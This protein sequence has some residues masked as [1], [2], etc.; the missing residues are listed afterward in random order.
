MASVSMNGKSCKCDIGK[1]LYGIPAHNFRTKQN[2]SNKDIDP[3]RTHLNRH[4]GPQSVEEFREKLRTMIAECDNKHPP[5][6]RKQDRKVMLELDIVSPR[7]GMSPED[8]LRWSE[9]T[10]EVI[11]KLFGDYVVGGTYHADEIHWYT[12]PG[13]TEQHLSRGHTHW[14]ILPW[15]DAKGLNMDAF[16]KR[17]LPN[18]IN[19]ALDKKCMEMFGFPFRDGSQKKSRGTVEQLKLKSTIAEREQVAEQVQYAKDEMETVQLFTKEEHERLQEAQE[20][21]KR[22]QAENKHPTRE[23]RGSTGQI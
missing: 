4:Y 1:A 21:K 10:A 6:R 17:S 23:N 2:H 16:Y 7:E 3:T 20:E 8:E 19:E 22:L 13:E 11:Y 12:P 15:T 9:A 18:K 14:S 5:K